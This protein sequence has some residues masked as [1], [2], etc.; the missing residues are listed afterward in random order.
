MLGT[1]VNRDCE[2]GMKFLSELGNPETENKLA[3]I[4]QIISVCLL[5]FLLYYLACTA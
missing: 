5:M 1:T 4:V 2:D 3:K